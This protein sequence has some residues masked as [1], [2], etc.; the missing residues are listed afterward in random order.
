M[1]KVAILEQVHGGQHWQ[2]CSQKTIMKLAYGEITKLK[3][4]KLMASYE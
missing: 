2:W 4:K 3:F 1:T